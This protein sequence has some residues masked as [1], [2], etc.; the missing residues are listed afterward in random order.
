MHR[1]LQSDFQMTAIVAI[2]TKWALSSVLKNA[3]VAW[4]LLSISAEAAVHCIIRMVVL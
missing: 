4:K 1:C 2:Q 3:V